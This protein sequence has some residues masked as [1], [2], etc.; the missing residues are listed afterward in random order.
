MIQ[1][2]NNNKKHILSSADQLCEEDDPKEILQNLLTI[3]VLNNFNKAG[4]PPHNL[5]LKEGDICI[6]LRNL[7][8]R[9]AN[10]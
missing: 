2:K 4:V 9:D 7:A 8:R 5:I 1:G 3:D 6:V 10:H